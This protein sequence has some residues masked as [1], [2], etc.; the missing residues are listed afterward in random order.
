MFQIIGIITTILI[1][2]FVLSIPFYLLGAKLRGYSIC[3]RRY[4]I[5]DSY[6]VSD[7][8]SDKHYWTLK[9][10]ARAAKRVPG[11]R[12]FNAFELSYPVVA[13]G[14]SEREN[15]YFGDYVPI[16]SLNSFLMTYAPRE[17]LPETLDVET[18]EHVLYSLNKEGDRL[19]G[20]DCSDTGRVAYSG[21]DI[22][23][24]MPGIV[25]KLERE[26]VA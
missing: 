21:A 24:N 9:G 13:P 5:V 25:S 19:I 26:A 2:I 23:Q 15:G 17:Q 4:R 14:W 18:V 1:G 12:I 8:D 3:L 6:G 10:A 22:V 20:V 11:S 16:H 7:P